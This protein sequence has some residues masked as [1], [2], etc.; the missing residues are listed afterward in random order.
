MESTGA[1]GGIADSVRTMLVEV[2][3]L[4]ARAG[5]LGADG[6]RDE[7]VVPAPRRTPWFVRA[8]NSIMVFLAV[9]TVVSGTTLAI[10]DEGIRG[11]TDWATVISGTLAG[12]L[13]II[14]TFFLR[15]NRVRAYEWFER[16]LLVDIL[17]TQVFNFAKYQLEALSGL[18]ITVVLWLMVRSALRAE[19]ERARWRRATP[20]ALRKLHRVTIPEKPSLDGLEEKWSARWEADADVPVR[21][22]EVADRRSTRSTPR[23]RR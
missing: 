18:V 13:I 5:V 22:H 9:F 6:P 23:R 21:P 4:P 2:P 19:R 14:G 20:V 3:A 8:V 7:V 10:D 16:G 12:V 1:S 15:S 17:L 11:F